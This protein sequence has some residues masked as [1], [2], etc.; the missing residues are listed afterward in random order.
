MKKFTAALLK[1]LQD[2]HRRP[3]RGGRDPEEVRADTNVEVATKE[4]ELMN[5]VREAGRT[6]VPLGEVDPERVQKIIDRSLDEVIR[7][8]R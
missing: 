8:A 1:G 5:A 4:L 3:G 2:A 7:R 6:R